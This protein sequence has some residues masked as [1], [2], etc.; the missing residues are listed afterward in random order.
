[1]WNGKFENK[2]ENKN[3]QKNEYGF[4]TRVRAK[5]FFLQ[6]MSWQRIDKIIHCFRACEATKSNRF[7]FNNKKNY[8][9]IS[10]KNKKEEFEQTK[11][12]NLGFLYL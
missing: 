1:M 4:Q 12:R 8:M 9:E 6:L 2:Y 7:C 11:P 5:K 10:N 3:Y